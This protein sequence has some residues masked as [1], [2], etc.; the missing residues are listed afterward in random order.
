MTTDDNQ[1]DKTPFMASQFSQQVRTACLVVM[2]TFALGA[3]MYFLKGILTPLMIA[4]FL[5][6]LLKPVGERLSASRVSIWLSYPAVVV[7][8][9]VALLFIGNMIYT[10]LTNFSRRL[11]VYEARAEI[12]MKSFDWL[13]PKSKSNGEKNTPEAPAKPK[14]D[15]TTG[16]AENKDQQETIDK[17]GEDDKKGENDK[18]D[19]DDTQKS[20]VP[21]AEN[22]PMAIA[23][24]KDASVGVET[25]EEKAFTLSGLLNITAEQLLHY[26]F[27][28]AVHF[29]EISVMVI[30]YL[31][32]MFLEA[33]NLPKRI[34]QN[35]PPEKA[36]HYLKI[37]ENINNN[38][39]QYLAYKSYISLGLGVST[40]L[41]CYLFGMDSWFLWGVLMFLGNYITYVG[42]M[43]ALVPPMVLALLEFESPLAGVI[44]A[45]LLI[46]NRFVWIDYIEIRYLGKYLNISPLLLLLSIALLG[47][48]WGMVGMILA[49]PIVTTV[50]IVLS[51][52][53]STREYAV[54]IS[55]E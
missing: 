37:G 23:K 32:F 1:N 13:K 18:K 49:V 31:I 19:K 5:Y 52:F 15:N 41:V 27:G 55:E 47:Y 46:L 53:E 7:L 4:L 24:A 12:L 2:A 51:H 44:L 21:I 20:D 28:T 29:L 35:I 14:T 6:F 34:R 30:F 36:G 9:C 50:R 43:V 25:G 38:V 48:I 16:A 40:G 45:A 17:K 33:K 39:R 3:A 26:V 10:N 42:S 54:L 22:K 8:F 11:P